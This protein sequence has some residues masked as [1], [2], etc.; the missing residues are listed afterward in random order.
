MGPSARCLDQGYE[1]GGAFDIAW[2]RF[3]VGDVND[4]SRF[5]ETVERIVRVVADL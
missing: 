3:E 2:L 5:G 4:T 1:A